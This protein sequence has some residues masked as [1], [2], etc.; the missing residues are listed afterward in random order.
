LKVSELA[1]KIEDDADRL[2][3]AQRYYEALV[4]AMNVTHGDDGTQDAL[5]VIE[6]IALLLG[7]LTGALDAPAADGA[8]IYVTERARAHRDVFE[9]AGKSARHVDEEP[10]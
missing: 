8:L 2:R 9:A 3:E 1:Q 6:G 7:Q 4:A 10:L 5:C